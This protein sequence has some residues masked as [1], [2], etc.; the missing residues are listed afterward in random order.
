MTEESDVLTVSRE[1]SDIVL[2]DTGIGFINEKS[3][4]FFQDNLFV[5]IYNV[6]FN[7]EEAMMIANSFN[8]A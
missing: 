6:N 5:S 3:V 1:F 2:L 8:L 4:S 7:L